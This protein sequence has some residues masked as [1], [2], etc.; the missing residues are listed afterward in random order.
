[1]YV[2]CWYVCTCTCAKCVYTMYSILYRMYIHVYCIFK[3]PCV[4]LVFILQNQK[5]WGRKTILGGGGTIVELIVL[6]LQC[7]WLIYT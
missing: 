4:P 1:M 7:F 3:F 5:Q 2:Q 6:P